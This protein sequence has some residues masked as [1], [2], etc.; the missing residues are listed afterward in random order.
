MRPMSSHTARPSAR[1]PA[2]PSLPD[3]TRGDLCPGVLRP[4]PAADGALVRLRLVGGRLP[5]RALRDLVGVAR[6]V[7]RRRR[8]PHRPGQ[9]PAPRP[10]ESAG[11]SPP[12][13]SRRSR[14]P[15][16]CPRAS[17]E[18][19]RNIMVVAADRAGRRPGRPA[20]PGRA[21]WT[22]CCAR[23]RPGGPARAVP[24]RA[25]RRPRRPGGPEP[26]T[27]G[28]VA[29]SDTTAQ[30]RIGSKQL[31]TRPAPARRAARPDRARPRLPRR[32]RHRPGRGL[33]RRRAGRGAGTRPP[34]DA[35][36][37]ASGPA[38]VRR[39]AGVAS[40]SPRRTDVRHRW[41]AGRSLRRHRPWSSPRGGASWC[42][43]AA[44]ERRAGSAS[45]PLRVRRRRAPTS[46]PSRSRRSGARP[47]SR[48]VPADAEKVAVRM[49]HGSG[50]VDLADD[51]VDPPRTGRGRPRR[52]AGRRADPH[53][54]ADGRHGRHP[55]RLPAGNEVL[56]FLQRR[57]GAWSR[58]AAWGTT[59]SAAAVSLWEP[60]LEGAVVAI[61]NAPT[62]LFHL[63]EMLIADG[64]P[65]PA[66]IVGMP[67]RV[68]RRGRV[69]GRPGVARRDHGI[70]LPYVTVRGRRGGSAMAVVGRERAR[71]GGRNDAGR[72]LRRRGRARRP[73][74]DH[75]QGRAADRRRRR[76]RLPLPAS[77]RQSNARSDRRA[78]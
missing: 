32:P 21:S 18:L 52:A 75:P 33:A 5:G 12:R 59:R 7:R 39:G 35:R 8:P 64:G 15:G 16:C 74:A 2:R 41:L 23:T 77:A 53:R 76:R 4:W 45:A 38:A 58:A 51:L 62:A 37:R 17:H 69:E 70:D 26:A 72:L 55:G 67:G 48:N 27:S 19:V 65:R 73:R 50:Q 36:V 3:R 60:R 28:L 66:A 6:S 25:R 47:T 43:A 63:L 71:A 61:G 78:T 20:T 11:G 13:S 31:G 14:R 42:R 44:D 40:T 49:V 68:R 9:P 34:A 56:C 57:P 1:R 10:A 22:G 24:V 29:V 54:R 30:L 46:T